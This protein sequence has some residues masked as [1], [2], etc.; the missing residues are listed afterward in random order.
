MAA[1]C[2]CESRCGQPPVLAARRGD[3]QRWEAAKL[4]LMTH[5]TNAEKLTS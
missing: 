2:D 3:C 1:S 4:L 5:R